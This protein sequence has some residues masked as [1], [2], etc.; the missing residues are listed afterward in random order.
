[1]HWKNK[2]KYKKQKGHRKG[3]RFIIRLFKDDRKIM[4]KVIFEQILTKNFP[5]LTK[6]I[7]PHIQEGQ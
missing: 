6:A 2:I 1:M 7:N 5:K 3:L 4:A